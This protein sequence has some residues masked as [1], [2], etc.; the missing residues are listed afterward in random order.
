LIVDLSGKTALITGGT[1]GIGLE[2][3]LAL[4]E[5]GARCVLTY[6]WGSADE[7]EVEEAWARAG[8]APPKLVQADVANA[9][10]TETLMAEIA[11]DHAGVDIFVSNVS[12]ALVVRSIEDYSLRGLHRSIDYTAW[13]LV[14]YTQAIRKTFGRYPRYVVGVSSCGVDHYCAGYDFVAASKA[15]L[16]A[17]CR[18][19]NYQLTGHGVRVNV[20]R[21]MNVRTQAFRDTF[22]AEFEAFAARFI[23]DEHVVHPREIADAILALVS[24]R[25]DAYA[26]QILTVDRG[27]TFFDNLMRLYAERHQLGLARAQ[28]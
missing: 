26:G 10:D 19:L 15:V 28:A 3:G 24:G 2:T 5:R 6:R 27:I 21:S 8:V 7:R 18:Y 23:R 4:A 1:M 13:P 17:L 16:E 22:G 14:S 25:L 11:A 20:V 9:D 12:T